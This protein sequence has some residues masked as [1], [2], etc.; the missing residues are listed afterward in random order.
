[1][2][3]NDKE[4]LDDFTAEKEVT[5]VCPKCRA[6]KDI[7]VPVHVI[8][9]A[10]Q[11]TTVSIPSGT[12]CEHSYQ[13]FVDKNFK[14]RM[15]QPVDFEFS[16]V[17]ILETL[18]EEAEGEADQEPLSRLSSLSI[19]NDI[20]EILRESV[21]DVEIMGSGLFTLEGRVLYS[22]LPKGTLTNVMREFEARS[23]KKLTQ[24]KKMFL[25]LENDRIICSKY[26]ELESSATKFVLV[27]FFSEKVK[28]GM[29]NFYLRGLAKKIAEFDNS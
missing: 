8:N 27:L 21:D 19:F 3:V 18:E 26:M 4:I 25:E 14:V 17:E 15:Y 24:I 10:K 11:L 20:I 16:K 23:E 7:K 22:S 6:K 5:I 13:A 9:Q 1:L 2:T 29:A 28:L 12:T